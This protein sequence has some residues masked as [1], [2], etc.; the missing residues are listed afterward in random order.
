MFAPRQNTGSFMLEETSCTTG[1]PNSFSILQGCFLAFRPLNFKRG[2]VFQSMHKLS[3][4]G[5][6]TTQ[7][8]ISCHFLRPKMNKDTHAR[9]RLGSHMSNMKAYKDL[10]LHIHSSPPPPTFYSNGM[11]RLMWIWNTSPYWASTH[12]YSTPDV[13]LPADQKSSLS[14]H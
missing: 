7:N 4:L 12:S 9:A 10:P 8:V 14:H 13:I 3:H 5:I 6:K 1:Y 2:G 11:R